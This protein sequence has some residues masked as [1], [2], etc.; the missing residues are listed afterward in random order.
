MPSGGHFLSC[1]NSAVGGAA[2]RLP[3]SA[4]LSFVLSQ[5]QDKNRVDGLTRLGLWT[6]EMSATQKGLSLNATKGRVVGEEVGLV[7]PG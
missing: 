2:R 4:E 3:P 1:R 6:A 7:V 5:Q